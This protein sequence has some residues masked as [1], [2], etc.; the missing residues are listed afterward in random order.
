MGQANLQLVRSLSR[1]HEVEVIAPVPWFEVLGD[2]RRG[3]RPA[4]GRQDQ[5]VVVRHP[6][7][8]YPPKVLHHRSGGFYEASVSRRFLRSVAEFRPDVILSVFAYPDGWAA[9]RLG[10][11][12]GVPVVLKVIGSD[13]LVATR[14]PKRRRKVRE[15]L[16]A[17]DGVVAVSQDLA[18]NAIRLGADPGLVRVIYQGIDADLFS[19]GDRAA[20]RARIGLPADEKIILFVGNIL[21]S[22]GAGVLVEAC[23]HLAGRGLAFRCYLIGQG[24]DQG[25]IRGLIARHGL[26]DR[27][28]LVGTRRS[29][30]L[31]DWY[32][33][34][35]V[36]SLPSYSEGIPNVLR[37]ARACGV[38]FVATRVGG[39]PE[40][41]EPGSSL[42]VAPGA[43]EEVA[44]GLARVLGGGLAPTT[45]PALHR[46]MS[47]AD[48]A[49][50]VV[51]ALHDAI[52]HR[53]GLTSRHAATATPP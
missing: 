47:W 19:P 5:G 17:A 14:N 49:D 11:R 40:I 51:G 37:E 48:S 43:P 25:R 41:A 26:G 31:P 10:R 36:V 9:V 39:I 21:H 44:D 13:V 29:D 53:A 20:A 28:T 52:R 45:D 38:P 1:E 46:S 30:Q 23:A 3:H 2:W 16:C 24:R 7:F 35:D 33:A 22:K 12:V 32:R 6:L 18:N 34:C 42:L 27:V 4:A 15:A 8:V 50:Q